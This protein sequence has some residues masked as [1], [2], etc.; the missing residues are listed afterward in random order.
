MS[1]CQDSRPLNSL[2]DLYQIL[3]SI[4]HNF[5]KKIIFTMNH[6]AINTII[7]LTKTY[8]FCQVVM[9]R[10]STSL[11]KIVRFIFFYLIVIC[12]YSI[13]DEIILC[14]CVKTNAFK[15]IKNL[16]QKFI[17]ILSL[18]HSHTLSLERLSEGMQSPTFETHSWSH[19][20]WWMYSRRQ[21]SHLLS[22]LI[23]NNCGLF[24]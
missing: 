6:N 9:I 21:N 11:S 3:I 19:P 18:S 8:L 14:A 23:L 10:V 2:F 22:N 1:T 13:N 17:R 7:L 24:K 16:I 20:E 12:F 15:G 4:L 5:Y